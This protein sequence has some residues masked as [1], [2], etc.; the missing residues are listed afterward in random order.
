MIKKAD[1]F[2]FSSPMLVD[3]FRGITLKNMS[4]VF[5][6]DASIKDYLLNDREGA[7]LLMHV[8]SQAKQNNH[9][10]TE[11]SLD[12]VVALLKEKREHQQKVAAERPTYKEMEWDHLKLPGFMEFYAHK[13][14]K[15]VDE[16]S[17]SA[18][19][20][21]TV[22]GP[23]ARTVDANGVERPLPAT[24]ETTASVNKPGVPRITIERGNTAGI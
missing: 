10:V 14:R 24:Q 13:A 4:D 1:I 21:T 17:G 12:D 8:R 19:G 7:G 23:N 2:D 9:N 22:H 15:L 6:S 18:Q 3:G 5:K 16:Y 11:L 20:T